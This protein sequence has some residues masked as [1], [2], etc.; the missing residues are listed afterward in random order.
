MIERRYRPATIYNNDGEYCAGKIF[1]WIVEFFLVV[2]SFWGRGEGAGLHRVGPVGV[3]EFTPIIVTRCFRILRFCTPEA[4]LS[5]AKKSLKIMFRVILVPFFL[6]YDV[7][8]KVRLS[9]FL[10]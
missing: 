8:T 1:A 3:L 7:H 5:F 9:Y 2:K 6:K 4:I 10:Q